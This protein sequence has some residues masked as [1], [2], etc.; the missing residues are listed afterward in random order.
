MKLY[1]D[2]EPCKECKDMITEL[3][4]ISDE[5]QA[6][7]HSRKILR[8]ITYNH[9]ELLQAIV[10]DFPKEVKKEDFAWFR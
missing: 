4:G 9:D 3:T 2:F 10:K 8:H 6:L 5:T 1:L 7:E